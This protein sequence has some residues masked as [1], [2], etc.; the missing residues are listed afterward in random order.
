ML[1]DELRRARLCGIARHNLRRF[2]PVG[3]MAREALVAGAMWDEP[4][5]AT[6]RASAASPLAISAQHDRAARFNKFASLSYITGKFN[7]ASLAKMLRE[8]GVCVDAADVS[9]IFY[10]FD[11]GIDN[12][13]T[14]DAFIQVTSTNFYEV[15]LGDYFL[16]F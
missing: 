16:T 4:A 6:T 13:I 11:V 5:A 9:I 15:F 8:A 10:H 3:D 7:E 14:R 2:V 1:A 12:Y